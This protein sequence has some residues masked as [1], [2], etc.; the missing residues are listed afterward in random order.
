M[1]TPA[2]SPSEDLPQADSATHTSES[3][4]TPE[5]AV[6]AVPVS[7]PAIPAPP[8][9]PSRVKEAPTAPV[10]NA[11]ARTGPAVLEESSDGD[12]FEAPLSAQAAVQLLE[13]EMSEGRR[14]AVGTRSAAGGN[15][16]GLVF[17]GQLLIAGALI[18]V[19]L[20]YD[21]AIHPGASY[22]PSV[23]V[24]V[25]SPTINPAA[26]VG[27]SSG[28]LTPF[29]V[30]KALYADGKGRFLVLALDAGNGELLVEKAL[31]LVND[32]TRL[33]G[34]AKRRDHHYYFEDIVVARRQIIKKLKEAFVRNIKSGRS[35]ALTLAAVQNIAR[36]LSSFHEAS[37]LVPY[38]KHERFFVRQ[39]A[40]LA[41][42]E[43]GYRIAVRELV[44]SMNAGN[45]GF[46]GHLNDVLKR[47]T[48]VEFMTDPS[49]E[50]QSAAMGRAREWLGKNPQKSPYTVGHALQQ[51]VEAR[52]NRG[53]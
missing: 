22:V 27:Q 32:P 42:G 13:K 40:A 21:K 38:L 46:R 14:E 31:E 53:L 23:P 4:P 11:R 18:F 49:K 17:L 51:K 3:E 33:H 6:E 48:G 26:L 39:A 12:D 15:S 9:T 10:S 45:K 50:D 35:D 37:F 43:K 28:Q 20:K 30:G 36:R 34:S 16:S 52:I 5:A 2:S 8:V 41:L 1:T 47:L 29:G 25:G 7:K 19:G 24:T 44:F